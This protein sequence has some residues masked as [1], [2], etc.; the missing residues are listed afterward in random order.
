MSMDFIDK[1]GTMIKGSY[2]S[3]VVEHVKNS[4]LFESIELRT[5][6]IVSVR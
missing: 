6:I 4:I 1:P 2:R 5:G 3:I